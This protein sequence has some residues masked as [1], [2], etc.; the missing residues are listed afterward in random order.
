[1]RPCLSSVSQTLW[2][3]PPCG[4][5]DH[6]LGRGQWVG[7]VSPS[8][9]AP[10]VPV[11]R[12]LRVLE[13]VFLIYVRWHRTPPPPP[14]PPSPVPGGGG[15]SS[16]FRPARAET[17]RVAG[18]SGCRAEPSL[19]LSGVILTHEMPSARTS[20][21][22]FQVWSDSAILA[23]VASLPPPPKAP[24]A[25]LGLGRPLGGHLEAQSWGWAGNP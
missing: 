19:G 24:G 9:S 5:R 2:A 21:P 6:M 3:L 1:M 12:E 14:P 17:V 18:A 4:C 13:C 11:G 10:P 7:D 15:S 8:G 22:K 25:G 23:V 20:E 16:L